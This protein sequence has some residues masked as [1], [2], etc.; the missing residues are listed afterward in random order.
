MAARAALVNLR[1]ENVL[2]NGKKFTEEIDLLTFGLK[3]VVTWIL[4][5]KVHLNETRA[6]VVERVPPTIADIVLIDGPVDKPGK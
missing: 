2:R 5:E 6:D 3:K 4:K 1:W